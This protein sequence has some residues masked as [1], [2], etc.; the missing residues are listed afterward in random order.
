MEFQLFTFITFFVGISC[1]QKDGFYSEGINALRKTV[2]EYKNAY[3]NS[4]RAGND[5]PTVSYY[6]RFKLI[7]FIVVLPISL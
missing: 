2:N 5:D 4:L 7:I 6:L 3:Q 1:L